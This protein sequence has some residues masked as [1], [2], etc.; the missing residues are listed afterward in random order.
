MAFNTYFYAADRE[1]PLIA[2]DWEQLHAVD[3]ARADRLKEMVDSLERW[4]HYG[5]AESISALW[6]AAWSGIA[7]ETASRRDTT[8]W[9]RVK[10]L[11][12]VQEGLMKD[13]G[14]I[15]VPLGEFQRLQR[16]NERAGEG[17]RDDRPS[18]PL[19]SAEGTSNGTIFSI[20]SQKP[21]GAKRRYAVG[22]SAYVSVMEFGPTVRA[23]S[24]TPFGESDD[25]ASPHFFDQA[26]LFAKGQFKPA[27][28]TMEEIRANLERSYHP[29][30]E[31]RSGGQR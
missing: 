13:F 16:P 19:P 14:T 17:Y 8:E 31:S 5:R 22:G 20:W 23:L 4:D 25:P 27:W 6:F 24:I 30:E 9:F 26:P 21:E 7:G 2:N 28:F 15:R 3:P 10:A 12:R 1:V 11:E 18:L 29:G